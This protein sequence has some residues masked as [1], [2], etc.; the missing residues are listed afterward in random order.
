MLPLV[1]V[2][3]IRCLL[4]EGE[5]SQRKIAIKLDVSRGTVSAIASG[6]R[7]VY[8]SE[9]KSDE[10]AL[11]CLELPPER[12]SGCG[13]KVYMPCVLC[14]AR[15]FQA[16]QDLLQHLAKPRQPTRLRVA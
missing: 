6:R 12:C 5:L 1:L 11:C 8:G 7:G 15:E 3:E 13:A 9:P 2:E 14:S 10:P 16:R 4:D